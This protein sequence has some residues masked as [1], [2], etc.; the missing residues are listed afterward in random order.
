MVNF[1]FEKYKYFSNIC[2]TYNTKRYLDSFS[3][4]NVQ[5]VLS[6]VYTSFPQHVWI[7]TDSLAASAA[8]EDFF[9]L[10]PKYRLKVKLQRRQ[11]PNIFIWNKSRLRKWEPRSSFWQILNFQIPKGLNAQCTDGHSIWNDLVSETTPSRD[12]CEHVCCQ[13]VTGPH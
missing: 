8:A 7:V 4:G 6:I 5:L 12:R 13:K 3:K 11:H 10:V 9:Q 2:I 1:T